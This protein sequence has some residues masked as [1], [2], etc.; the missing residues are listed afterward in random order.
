MTGMLIGI[1]SLRKTSKQDDAVELLFMW[2]NDWNVL[3][4]A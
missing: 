1:Y 3:S 4:S 2:E